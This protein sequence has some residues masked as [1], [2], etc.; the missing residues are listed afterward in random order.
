M[1]KY[2][3]KQKEYTLK[4][5]S[6]LHLVRFRVK[7]EEFSA[8]EKYAESHNYSSVTAFIKDAIKTAMEREITCQNSDIATDK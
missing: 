1:A 5:L 3:Q 8:I 6:T 7:E 2:T 4:Y